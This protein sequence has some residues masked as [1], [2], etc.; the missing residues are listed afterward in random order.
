MLGRLRRLGRSE[1][2]A[3]APLFAVSLFALIA[4]GGIAF[5]YARLA[6]MDTELQQAADLAALAAATQLDR[7]DEAITRARTAVE[8]AAANRLAG[9]ITRFAN[10]GNGGGV[11]VNVAR[12]CSEYDDSDEQPDPILACTVTTDGEAARF[13]VVTTAMRT[14]NYALTPVVAA[15]SGTLSATAVAGIESSICNVAPLFVCT[16]DAAFPT[17]D[18]VGRGIRMKTGAQNSW[19]PGNYGLLD[20]GSGNSGVI[21]ALL[22]QGMN[23]C[24]S[25]DESNTKPGNSNITDAINVRFDLYA[26]TGAT[27][28]PDICDASDGTGC[29]DQNTGK[30]YTQLMTYEIRQLRTLP[31]PTMPECGT[32]AT[33]RN[34]SPSV[35]YGQPV[36]STAAQGM[37]RDMCHYGPCSEENFGDGE[38][39]VAGY[40]ASNHPAYSIADVPSAGL[41]PT[42]YEVYQWEIVNRNAA[43]PAFQ[44]LRPVGIPANPTP[45]TRTQGQNTTY[46]FTRQCMFRQPVQ[47]PVAPGPRRVLPVVAA[48]CESLNGAS[49]LDEF[50]AIRVF[51]VFLTEPSANRSAPRE[52]DD[53]EIYGEVMGPAAAIGGGSGF[54]YYARNKPFL[55]R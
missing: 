45:Q 4:A 5:D 44:T 26:G 29:P 6:G 46:T 10:D 28:N 15:F 8:G 42:R 19:F 18:D 31:A 47:A 38:W 41:S 20:L 48:S 32:P 2:G 30:D 50:N 34:A 9:N 3:I 35:T 36:L 37:P 40:M 52:T 13:V 23:G 55:I 16:P 43:N 21:D 7:S 22:G 17:E 12:F 27:N 1:Q 33:A 53:K 11:V 14:A 39:D 25:L 24:Q 54:Q 49:Q 51:N